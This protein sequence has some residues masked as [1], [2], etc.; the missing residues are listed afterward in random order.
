MD[1]NRRSVL[2]TGVAAAA[3]AGAPGVFAQQ[4]GEPFGE[5][6]EPAGAPCTMRSARTVHP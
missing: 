2:T 6:H 3:M 4:P 1:K 5:G